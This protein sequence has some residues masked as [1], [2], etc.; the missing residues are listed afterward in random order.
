[1]E[2][3]YGSPEIVAA[4]FNDKVPYRVVLPAIEQLSGEAAAY[5]IEGGGPLPFRDGQAAYVSYE[6]RGKP[7]SMVGPAP[8]DLRADLGL[9]RASQP[10][11][12]RVPCGAQRSPVHE[13][14]GE[15]IAQ[16]VARSPRDCLSDNTSQRHPTPKKTNAQGWSVSRI[17]YAAVLSSHRSAS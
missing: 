13:Q 8:R 14:P 9:R 11:L 2:V 3:R 4:W 1:M 6:V 7:G 10:I 15:P 17:R 16:I 5:R 12:H